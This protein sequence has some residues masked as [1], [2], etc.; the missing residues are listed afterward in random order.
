[1]P[2]PSSPS[3]SSGGN[4]R[5]S[6]QSTTA[7]SP[8]N[9]VRRF[10]NASTET[11]PTLNSLNVISDLML[12]DQNS[13]SRE[14]DESNFRARILR[15]FNDINRLQN[16]F[17]RLINREGGNHQASL[18]LNNIPSQLRNLSRELS[19]SGHRE[20]YFVESSEDDDDDDDDDDADDQSFDYEDDDVANAG[21]VYYSDEDNNEGEVSGNDEDMSAVLMEDA[22]QSIQS[23]E[24]LLLASA[25]NPQ[26]ARTPLLNSSV[27]LRRQNAIRVRSMLNT[28]DT[29]VAK[30]NDPKANDF[31]DLEAESLQQEIHSVLEAIESARKGSPL[32]PNNFHRPF[33]IRYFSSLKNHMQGCSL[34]NNMNADQMMDEFLRKRVN[35]MLFLK[36]RLPPPPSSKRRT[37]IEEGPSHKRQKTTHIDD[38]DYPLDE[39]VIAYP[40]TNIDKNVLVDGLPSS[41]FQSGSNYRINLDC[42]QHNTCDMKLSSVSSHVEGVFSIAPEGSLESLLLKLHNF[43]KFFC[44][45][46][47]NTFQSPKNKILIRKLNMLDRLSVD[48]NVGFK[49]I[50]ASTIQVPF[51]GKVVDFKTNDLRFLNSEK[52]LSARFNLNKIKVQLSEW[53]KINPFIQFRE[54][55]FY[56][57]L[58]HLDQDLTHFG[59]I[60]IR[61]SKKTEAIHLTKEFKSSLPEITKY[62]E[63]LKDSQVP[64]C[65][66]RSEKRRCKRHNDI[67]IEDWERNLAFRLAES[68]TKEDCGTLINLQ[69]NYALFTIEVDISKYLD[70][71]INTILAH[72]EGEYMENYRKV[73]N[74][75]LKD[76]SED[77]TAI[78]LC[79]IDKQRG[80]LEIHNTVSHLHHRHMARHSTGI[81]L[82]TNPFLNENTGR[83]T[84]VYDDFDLFEEPAPINSDTF[85]KRFFH[86]QAEDAID[87]LTGHVTS[88]LPVFDIV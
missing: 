74:N 25:R 39:P 10:R 71:F 64:P 49:N 12:R 61:K 33:S 67:F 40:Y 41:Y 36:I 86:N 37:K 70:T 23:N 48:D 32:F 30:N 72:S 3:N 54:N 17:N 43:A 73:Y 62:F 81:I 55:F 57:F 56:N 75:I 63:Y 16:H 44:G 68:V 11:F 52:P 20:A 46:S 66:E 79:S 76:E 50:N 35:K 27:P 69:L 42:P 38:G 29:E 28:E 60:E 58:Q 51:K 4:Q 5:P 77:I 18:A 13:M 87:K 83:N 9:D 14:T 85:N 53:M 84:Y 19:R 6:N 80:K 78:L 59:D 34:D 45:M 47:N 26:T 21:L 24:R 15:H 8:L 65:L 88:S 7:G 82:T 2:P 31:L 22:E 1:M